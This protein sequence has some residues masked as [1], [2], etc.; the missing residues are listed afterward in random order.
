MTAP[1]KS[2]L[3]DAIEVI[4]KGP[5]IEM[6][7]G[8]G[9]LDKNGACRHRARLRWWDPEATT[10]R[11]AADL[12]GGGLRNCD[13]TPFE[14]LPETPFGRDSLP[15]AETDVPVIFGHYWR[16]GPPTVD[17]LRTACVDYSVAAGGPLVAYRWSG[18]QEVADANFV[19]VPHRRP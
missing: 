3:D 16:T 17:G 15:G 2:P 11:K 13:E 18:E 19:T 4:L 12:P 7:G 8:R 14:P 1:K 6:G 10:L 5:E 9:Y